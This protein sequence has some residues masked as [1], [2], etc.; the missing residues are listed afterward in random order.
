MLSKKNEYTLTEPNKIKWLLNALE[1]QHQVVIL[2][3]SNSDLLDRSM[4]VSV[5]AEKHSFMLEGVIDQAI[6][7]KISS[8]HTFSL[9]STHNGVDLLGHEMS[10]LKTLSDDQSVL[11]EVALPSELLYKQRRE[12]YRVALSDAFAVPV[13]VSKAG[14]KELPEE[15]MPECKLSNISA[16]GCLLKFPGTEDN[17][18]FQL[19]QVLTLAFH[20]PGTDTHLSL[21]AVVCHGRYISRSSIWLLGFKFQNLSSEAQSCLGQHVVRLQLLARQNSMMS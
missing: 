16:E 3:L 13:C 12:S 21:E 7:Q 6:H 10:A 5:C 8:G 15:T 4:V 2:S 11:Y 19:E 9:S 17:Q 1:S 20:V 18:V 14:S